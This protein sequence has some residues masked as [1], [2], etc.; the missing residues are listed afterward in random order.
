MEGKGKRG[1]E[2]ETIMGR[3][4]DREEQEVNSVKGKIG[5]RKKLLRKVTRGRRKSHEV[6]REERGRKQ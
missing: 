5:R 4:E 6:K 3:E 1:E 2:E